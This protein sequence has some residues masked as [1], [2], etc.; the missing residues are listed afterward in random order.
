MSQSEVQA[1]GSV[2]KGDW[3]FLE[4][5]IGHSGNAVEPEDH[6]VLYRL[7]RQMFPRDRAVFVH[8]GLWWIIDA[9]RRKAYKDF[10]ADKP[11][12]YG[13]DRQEAAFCGLVPFY[14]YTDEL[15]YFIRAGVCQEFRGAGI[16]RSMIRLREEAARAKG[17]W[18]CVTTT[19]CNPASSNNLI[20]EGWR[21]YQPVTP[22]MT[23]GTQ[24]W[25]K[26][27]NPDDPRVR[28]IL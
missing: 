24:Y 6:E 26:V 20:E 9:V 10:L 7:H 1:N 15:G 3:R 11:W 2:I 23:Q 8:E 25:R 28:S 13:R 16:Q 27:L 17:W 21:Q 18:G 19:Y 4:R 14:Q 22:W 5:A 12:K